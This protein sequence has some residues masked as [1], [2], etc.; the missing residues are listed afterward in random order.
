MLREIRTQLFII[1]ISFTFLVLG[2]FSVSYLYIQDHAADEISSG[3]IR[4]HRL[5]IQRLTWLA[6]VDPQNPSV[7][8]YKKNIENNLASVPGTGILI[9]IEGAPYQLP[10][11]TDSQIREQYQTIAQIWPAYLE[12]LE[13]A[14]SLPE[15][16]RADET[17]WL[18]L[19]S[20]SRELIDRVDSASEIYKQHTDNQHLRLRSL[21]IVFILMTVP[22]LISGIYIIG[23]RIVHPLGSL[24]QSA[25]SIRRG[26]LHSSIEVFREDEIGQLAR[27]MERMR[28]QISA[29]Q[30]NLEASIAERTRELTTATKFSQEIAKVMD[31]DEIIKSI[32]NLLMDLFYA[33]D[34]ALC[35][36]TPNGEC[37]EMVANGTQIL[38]G[39]RPQQFPNTN[40]LINHSGVVRATDIT[41]MGCQ[42]I[43]A[44]S[45]DQVMSAS[46]QVGEKIIGAL[47]VQ[48]GEN[49]P[50][51]ENEQR[52]FTLLANSAA[53]AIYNNQ[54]VE[55]GKK[56]VMKSARLA[57]RERLASELHDDLAQNLGVSQ[58]QVN[59][60][61]SLVPTNELSE[62]THMLETLQA[63]LR[64]AQDQLRLVIRGLTNQ[65]KDN[66]LGLQTDIKNSIAD[67]N[68][69]CDVPVN[70]E[71]FGIP[72]EGASTIVQRQ[73]LLI[74]REALVNIRR[75]AQASKVDVSIIKNNNQIDMH[76]K[77]NG[78]GF[79][80]DQTRGDQHFGLEIMQARA[81]RSGGR[82]EI[83]SSPGSG[84]EIKAS[85][86]LN[87]NTLE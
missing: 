24:N 12:K 49:R 83:I 81:E 25:L 44:N 1:I 2:S 56:E 55:V 15:D 64:V 75:H 30:Q 27:S 3:I 36:L 4:E 5:S 33:K 47:C 13:L 85:F 82:L 53:I 48:R 22:L 39:D 51:N 32:T 8:I 9:P 71:I 76:I 69:L 21:Q 50:F 17:T 66:I 29:N 87:K 41:R 72:W 58:L 84:T 78:Q 63:N 45:T 86:P 35:L 16:T 6:L 11:P 68:K 67:F 26:D 57:E 62:I 74:L 42:F 23:Y 14:L 54:L 59:Q 77:D 19:Q 40:L 7:S 18:A 46:L 52:I 31:A 34:V 80:H 70:L 65:P 43:N 61:L 20:Q 79:D 28:I 60:I 73:L 38:A 37:I 10:G